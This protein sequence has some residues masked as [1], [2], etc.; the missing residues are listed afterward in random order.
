M[1]PFASVS[2]QNPLGYDMAAMPGKNSYYGSYEWLTAH[3]PSQF[4]VYD[5]HEFLSISSWIWLERATGGLL[6]ASDDA[7][8]LVTGQERPRRAP[9]YAY[10]GF[11]PLSRFIAQWFLTLMSCYWVKRTPGGVHGFQLWCD[12]S[13]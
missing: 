10:Y 11:W 12:R 2:S 4:G 8:L 7:C 5:A 3:L 9:E 13:S 1:L 6:C